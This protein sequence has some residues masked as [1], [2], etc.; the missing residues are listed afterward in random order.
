MG[1]RL[2]VQEELKGT[3][4]FPR[5]IYKR[6]SWYGTVR[7]AHQNDTNYCPCLLPS[8]FGEKKLFYLF[9]TIDLVFHLFKKGG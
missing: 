9:L 5:V 4:F 2:C 6:S 7:T 3:G 8:E 1:F